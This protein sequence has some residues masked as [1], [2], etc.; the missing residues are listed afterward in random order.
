MIIDII[1]AIVALV[2][3]V[4]GWRRGFVVQLCQLVALYIAI[5]IAPEFAGQI[6]ASFS[7]DPGL[8]YIIGFVI[9][10]VGAWLVVWIIAP[11]L[12][13]ILFWDFLRNVDSLLGAALALVAMVVITSVGC[14][15]FRTANIGEVRTDKLL[16]LGAQNLSPEE[17]AEYVEKIENKDISMREYFESRYIDYDTLNESRLFMPLASMG[18]T[19]CPGLD[20][21]KEEMME[22]AVNIA[23]DERG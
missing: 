20:D 11:L 19:L 15:L 9:I 7:D 8:A 3:L 18:D 22:I 13:K 17:R 12:R 21:F 1:I 5:L 10:I 14:S 2:A 4:M 16:E 23:A 6:G